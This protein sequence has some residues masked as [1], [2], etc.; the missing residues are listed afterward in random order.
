M[1]MSAAPSDVFTAVAVPT[2][3]AHTWYDWL[4]K[5]EQT[6]A[7]VYRTQPMR[8]ISDFRLEGDFT[9][10]YQGREILELLQNANDAATLAQRRGGVRFEILPC[11]LIAAN[12]GEPFSEEGVGSLCL[13]FTSP[14]RGEKVP[15]VGNKGLGFRAVLNW[16]RFP[17]I[18][19]GELAIVFSVRVAA[20]KQAEMEQLDAALRECIDKHKGVDGELVVPLLAFPGFSSDGDLAA[21]LDTDAQ[22]SIYARCRE[23]REAGYDTVI[24]MPFDR[25]SGEN[26]ARAQIKLLRPEVLLFARSVEELEIAVEGEQPLCWR[27]DPREGAT[28]RVYLGAG[29]ADYREWN[30]YSKRGPVPREHLP[31]EQPSSTEYELVL[32]IPAN[33][34]T[35]AGFLYSYFPTEVRFPYPVVC[36]ATLDLQNNRQQPQN[37]PANHFV[38]GQLA[39]FMTETA[40]RLARQ[41]SDEYG[42][43]LIA[44][45]RFV[46]DGLEKFGFRSRLLDAAKTR[47][48]VPTLGNG[49]VAPDK[50]RRVP[51]SETSWLP[52][53]SFS[54]V[55]KLTNGGSLQHVLE[56]L[57]VP[58]LSAADWLA[59]QPGLAFETVDA[60]ADF[61][62]GIVRHKV[63]DALSLSG[64][65]LDSEGEAVPEGYRV[66]LPPTMGPLSLPEWFEVRFL[67][68]GL[69]RAIADRLDPKD[70]DGLASMLSPL[71]VSRYSLD[72]VISALVGQ[73]N[74][75]AESEPDRKGAVRRDLLRAL[76]GLFPVGE[77]RDER[78]RFPKDAR[79]LLR[80]QAG[81]DE[82][83]RKLYLGADYGS[84][85]RILGALYGSFA[86]AKIVAPPS[87][88][89]L[90]GPPESLAE[91]LVWLGVADLPR[92]IKTDQAGYRFRTHVGESLAFPLLVGDYFLQNANELGEIHLDEVSSIDDLEKLFAHAEPTAILAWLIIDDRAIHWKSPAREYGRFG[93][94][95][96][97]DHNVRFFNGPIPSYVRWRLQTTK[98]LPTRDGQLACP[99]ECVAET[100]RGLEDLLPTPKRPD[101]GQLAYYGIHPALLRDAFD[102]SGVIP[103]FSQIDPEQLYE[104]LLSLPARDQNG[105]MAKSVYRAI[106][107][108]FDVTDLSSCP[109]RD[110]F[111][112]HGQM[113]ARHG[114]VELYCPVAELWHVDSEDIPPALYRK[115]NIA[116]LPRRSGSQKVEGLFGVKALERSQITRRISHYQPVCDAQVFIDEIEQLKPLI[117]ALRRS[118]AQRARE[119]STF[120]ELKIVVCSSIEGEVEF[121]GERDQ[122]ELGI[123]DWILDDQTHTA[124]VLSNPAEV[125]PL[126]SDL[127]FDAVGQIFAAVFRIE[128][129]DEFVRLVACQRK[130][131]LKILKRLVGDE[132]VPA[133]EELERQY[134]E[135]VAD[136]RNQE[137]NVPHDALALTTSPAAPVSEIPDEE[138]TGPAREEK[139]EVPLQVDS[140]EHIPRPPT[141]RVECRVNRKVTTGPRS[142]TGSKRVTDGTFCEYKAM[143]FEE[144]DTPPRFP[145]RVGGI[146]GWKGPRVDVLSFASA[147]DRA[148]F[149]AGDRRE[150]LVSR[151]IEVKGRASEGAKID[152]RDNALE[153]ARA[154]G[155]RYF[156]YRF[157]NRGDGGYDLA[158]LKH[159]LVD[160][161]GVRYFCE[162]NLDAATRTEEFSITGGLPEDSYL[163]QLAGSSPAATGSD[164]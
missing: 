140:K 124:Y 151:F 156:L 94:R 89:G 120:K 23:L 33:H 71:G 52:K 7:D 5:Q 101:L 117:L 95:R 128:R 46:S 122:L 159:P 67:H 143:E 75:R 51:F 84:W 9:R 68:P 80:T 28:S 110:R 17:L 43:K 149:L 138:K 145:I 154:Y 41:V 45:E 123:W 107:D 130:D 127:L 147:E 129:G 59:A 111:V 72:N 61:V 25:D 134:R 3:T 144:H 114:S 63:S 105:K 162:V 8:L 64:I 125:E 10:D 19:S 12:T 69:R 97:G 21:F 108:H 132:D 58:P 62:A 53:A 57:A 109:A 54:R 48:L 161:T 82:D 92:E 148:Q 106:L 37:T 93:S 44:G 118:Q 141:A 34:E 18:L 160:E 152:L 13:P 113:W 29:D 158:I 2:T 16:T 119:S 150:T 102:R 49:I 38:L 115:F 27:H 96:Y 22:R 47:E 14:K 87:E 164:P 116:A 146:T 85:G 73:A 104:L 50:A 36:H 42:L 35:E 155:D 15:M 1:R 40:E 20:R 79:V 91:F 100:L 90:D 30:V 139:G 137:V 55:V 31:A 83:A 4:A 24:G 70:Q 98:W 74:R 76:L 136:A 78:P 163:E 157:F 66:F 112:Q 99:R 153:A 131:R 121:Q 88:L 126:K 135:I 26:T 32:A 65:L 86:S 60:R 103:G 142:F 56:E 77:P 133:M 11:G 39:E 81:S 6:T